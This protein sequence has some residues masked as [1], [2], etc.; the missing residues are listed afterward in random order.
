MTCSEKENFFFSIVYIVQH[1]RKDQI[2][3][4]LIIFL[5]KEVEALIR[6]A[7]KC[8]KKKSDVIH[9]WKHAEIENIT[10]IK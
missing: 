4:V 6:S 7:K 2:T 10:K 9:D 5:T 3:V 8:K 1:Q